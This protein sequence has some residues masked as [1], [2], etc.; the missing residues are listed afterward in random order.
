MRQLC[1]QYVAKEACPLRAETLAVHDGAAADT[2][3]D[4]C[5]PSSSSSSSLHEDGQPSTSAS[6][7]AA[8]GGDVQ[9]CNIAEM[10]TANHQPLQKE[11]SSSTASNV[12]TTSSMDNA[13]NDPSAAPSALEYENLARLVPDLGLDVL[14]EEETTSA[15]SDID[16]DESTS[17]SAS[18]VEGED[19]AAA[20]TTNDEETSSPGERQ[21]R[22][23]PKTPELRFSA[24]FCDLVCRT[25]LAKDTA[26]KWIKEM[27]ENKVVFDL[28]TM[29]ISWKTL[30]KPKSKA[31][32]AFQSKV[33]TFN[34][35]RK[36]AKFVNFG[37]INTLRKH[38]P[39]IMKA[40]FPDKRRAPEIPHLRI[41]MNFDG[42][43]L[44]ETGRTKDLWPLCITVVAIGAHHDGDHVFV[45]P[46]ARKVLIIAMFLGSAKPKHPEMILRH[47]VEDLKLLDPRPRSDRDLDEL[48]F[49]IRTIFTVTLIRFLADA[50]AR[51]LAKY[52]KGHA[53]SFHCE[54]CNH[55]ALLIHKLTKLCIWKVSELD[56]RCDAEFLQYENHV[57]KVRI[58]D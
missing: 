16:D 51:A 23:R 49:D 35:K 21:A 4:A 37:L 12:I 3:D 58:L 56:L 41:E 22:N 5:S 2:G 14:M 17:S 38:L 29:N 54:K 1:E 40:T 52:I 28:N 30:A 20:G 50:P 19:N 11:G 26:M 55:R 53:S 15:E 34:L 44:G 24:S 48:E 25:N 18:A 9:V 7:A 6:S 27:K 39:F 32:Q 47:A 10:D 43:E 31:D 13:S 46:W 45:P 8:S 42:V 57:K 33:K 36:Q